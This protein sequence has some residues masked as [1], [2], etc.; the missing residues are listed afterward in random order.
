MSE[1][2]AAAEIPGVHTPAGRLFGSSD[3]NPKN[4]MDSTFFVNLKYCSYE[5]IPI[6]TVQ[7][8]AATDITQRIHSEKPALPPRGSARE[9]RLRTAADSKPDVDKSMVTDDIYF[10]FRPERT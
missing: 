3:Y 7:T 9:P 4:P 6:N 8:Q 10:P 5:P 2:Q 1:R